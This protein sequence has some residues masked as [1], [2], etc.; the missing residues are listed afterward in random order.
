MLRYGFFTARGKDGGRA[1]VNV[2]LD[3]AVVVRKKLV[4][5][6]RKGRNI[7][8]DKSGWGMGGNGILECDGTKRLFIYMVQNHSFVCITSCS[9]QLVFTDTG[10][11]VSKESL[12]GAEAF[13]N[14][15]ISTNLIQH[16]TQGCSSVYIASCSMQRHA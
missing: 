5:I 14:S 10:I 8:C 11:S 9:L 13:L 3:C 1:G 6:T 16:A 15:T 12:L 2:E 4:S 7:L